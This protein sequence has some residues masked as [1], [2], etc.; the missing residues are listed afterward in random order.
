MKIWMLPGGKQKDEY[1]TQI[2]HKLMIVGFQL[3]SSWFILIKNSSF[4]ASK[5]EHYG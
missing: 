3:M 2:T 4:Q 1:E 5:T